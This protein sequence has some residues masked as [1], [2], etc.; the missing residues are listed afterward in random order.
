MRQELNQ[1]LEVSGQSE[2]RMKELRD[3]IDRR[4]RAAATATPPAVT[5]GDTI[6]AAPPVDAGPGP[7]DLLQI[8]RDQLA[9]G[10]N[11][12]ARAAFNDLLARFPESEL[13]V[14]AQFYL[15]EAY[16]AEGTTAAADSAY[17][18]VVDKYPTSARASTAFYKRGVMA[19]TAGRRTA[20]RRLY[21]E[22][23]DKYPS[24]DEAELARERLRV[25]N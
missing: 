12:A 25:M 3:Q 20:A 21:N 5:S 9:R 7:A 16:A 17:Q 19:Q 23:I 11:S 22:L 6:T 4:A 1:V 2:R 15:A 24:S 8:G 13:A 14:E 10:G 18:T